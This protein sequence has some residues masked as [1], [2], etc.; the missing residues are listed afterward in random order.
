MKE[1]I[2]I[3][4][5]KGCHLTVDEDNG[6]AVSGNTC[7]RGAE[8]G[9]TECMNP[10]RV[11]TGTVTIKNGTIERCP[12]KTRGSI[13]KDMVLIAESEVHKAVITAPVRIGDVIIQ[14]I[15]GTGIDLVATKNIGE[16]AC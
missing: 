9:K 8:Y 16:K 11:L 10:V 12:V 14:N 13:P 7:D 2:C 15:C 5:P 1:L 6:Y 4:C 3:C